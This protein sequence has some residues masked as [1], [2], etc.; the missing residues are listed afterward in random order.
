MTA[1]KMCPF[2]QSTS[3]A[4]STTLD[5]NQS[6]SGGG[7]STPCVENDCALWVP[8]GNGGACAFYLQGQ[9]ALLSIQ[10]LAKAANP[11]EAANENA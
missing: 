2:G 8:C 9:A 3:A 5:G 1:V 6:V 4:I 11:M 7:H 10:A